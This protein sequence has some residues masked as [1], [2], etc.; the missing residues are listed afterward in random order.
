VQQ[1]QPLGQYLASEEI[2]ACR[3]AVRPVEARDE[4][5]FF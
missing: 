1:R 5:G 3:V 4:A 2:D